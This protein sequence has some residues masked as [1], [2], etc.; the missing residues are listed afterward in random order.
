MEAYTK[1]EKARIVGSRAL[2]I[3][4]GAPILI[5]LTPE[6][7]KS[8]GFNPIKIAMTEFE[9]GV[10]PITVKRPHPSGEVELKKAK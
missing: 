1:F 7:I 2:Q 8:M 9:A 5:K 6:D 4:M 3:S 10:I